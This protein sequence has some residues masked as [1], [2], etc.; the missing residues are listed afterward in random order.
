ML[1]TMQKHEIVRDYLSRECAVGWVLGPE[2][3]FKC[4]DQPK[5]G[6]SKRFNR[7]M[8]FH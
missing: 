8:A 2:L 3:F 4:K 1:S 6:N 5:W 7:K